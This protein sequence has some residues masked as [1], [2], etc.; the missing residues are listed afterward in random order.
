MEHLD[1]KVA[2]HEATLAQM[3]E[4]LGNIEATLRDLNGRLDAGFRDVNQRM[5]TMATAMATKG[6]LRW[7]ATLISGLI[8]IATGAILKYG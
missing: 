8:A 3:N 6:E 1:E 5:A 7:W 4:R 2:A